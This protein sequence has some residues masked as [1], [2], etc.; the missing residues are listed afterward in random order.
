MKCKNDPRRAHS[1]FVFDV[2]MMNEE[3]QITIK[4]N[5]G[6]RRLASRPDIGF[7]LSLSGGLQCIPLIVLSVFAFMQTIELRPSDC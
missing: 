5:S 3:E 2:F 1:A 7:S 6:C 4:R